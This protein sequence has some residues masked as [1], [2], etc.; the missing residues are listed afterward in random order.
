MLHLFPVLY[1]FSTTYTVKKKYFTL[2]G[3]VM[4]MC[5]VETENK[6]QPLILNVCILSQF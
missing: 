4:H 3:W 6:K 2:F 5:F 1:H